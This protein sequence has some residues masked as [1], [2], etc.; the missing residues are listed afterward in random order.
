DACLMS[1]LEVYNGLAPYSH[2]AV[3]SQ[4]TEPGLGWAY[5]SFLS[6]LAAQPE[7][8]GA[9]LGRAIV[10]SY[11]I[12]D[13]R[14][15]NDEARQRMLSSFGV[16]EPISAGE[17]A[18]EWATDITLAAVDLSAM[19]P[20]NASLDTFLYALKNVDQTKVAEARSYAQA[21]SSAFGDSYPSPYIDLSNFA[22]FVV[23]T[24]GDQALSQSNQQLQTALSGAVIAEKHG[25]Q[26][27]GATGI[28]FYF[29]VSELY[30]DE[31]FGYT[32][33]TEATRSSASRNLWDDFLAFHYT[34]QE[35]GLGNPSREARL[36]APGAGQITIAPLTLSAN[37]I[38][39]GDILNIQTDISGDNVAY[40]YLVGLIKHS[41]ENR[42]L[43]YFMDYLQYDERNLVQNG[44]VY[45]VWD[46][47]NGLIH[48]N[49]DWD[50]VE[51]NVCDGTNCVVA[52]L[53]PD[54][55]TAQTEN[56][57]YYVEGWYIYS[58]T[59]KRI[60]ATMYFYSTEGDFLIR[61]IIANP[62]GNDSIVSPSALIP[63]PGDQFLTM[64]T[65]LTVDDS[66]I[67]HTT[68]HE[69]NTLTFGDQPFY[70]GYWGTPEPGE[71]AFGI[72]VKDMDGNVTWQFAP[73]TVK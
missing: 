68:Y 9:D 6:D 5:A 29:P 20:L 2:Y 24:T 10:E 31:G 64:N 66:G 34:G 55:Y 51:R 16:S 15:L 12:E 72:Y 52:L 53:N 25:D 48:I 7:M 26:R 59:G 46:R 3:A 8:S 4:E 50:L 56:R 44:V 32:Y 18:Q 57:I 54:K 60:K 38:Q 62:V 11:I 41:S 63:K 71:Y 35:F 37:S 1:M 45:P 40:I 23:V 73:V 22:N 28:S 70:R 69:G 17:L 65:E 30:W 49:L 19:P 42:Y 67:I 39:S 13:Q 36:P 27:Q 33:Y 14:I 43:L 58:E 61:N 47:T 21:F